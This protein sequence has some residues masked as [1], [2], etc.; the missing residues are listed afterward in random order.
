M[1]RGVD[2]NRG[3]TLLG[4]I[5]IYCLNLNK[6]VPGPPLSFT[7][8]YTSPLSETIPLLVVCQV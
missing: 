5:A 6:T 4:F 2:A 7:A 8:Q 1:W 3:P